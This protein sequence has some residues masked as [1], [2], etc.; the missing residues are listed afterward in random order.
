VASAALRAPEAG[1]CQL[2]GQIPVDRPARPR[3]QLLQFGEQRHSSGQIAPAS[4]FTVV[5]A[6]PEREIAA[7]ASHICHGSSDEQSVLFV[8]TEAVLRRR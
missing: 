6:E 2:P 8:P 7:A 5:L 3:H 1:Y 4:G